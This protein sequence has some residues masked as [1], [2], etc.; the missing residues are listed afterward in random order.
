MT[1]APIQL[2]LFDLLKIETKSGLHTPVGSSE[3]DESSIDLFG[4]KSLFHE[5]VF[6]FQNGWV[7][8]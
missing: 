5:E 1:V 8:F 4:G 7:A 2:S 3:R 6:L